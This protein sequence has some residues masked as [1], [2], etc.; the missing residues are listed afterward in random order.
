MS[1]QALAAA[2]L[3]LMPEGVTVHD[4]QVP[5]LPT[6]PYVAVQVR[7]PTPAGRAIS[8]DRHGVVVR[9]LVTVAAGTAE[10]VRIVA[11]LVDDAVD[12]AVPVADGFTFGRVA[13]RNVRVTAQDFSVTIPA[14]KRHPVYAV[15][16]YEFT[17][18][19]ATPE[20]GP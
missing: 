1:A 2:F 16:E 20:V 6:Y 8:F 10:G 4:V 9:A 11:D 17:A 12:G 15:L 13:L 3:A 14:S 18:A 19:T 7:I 5:D